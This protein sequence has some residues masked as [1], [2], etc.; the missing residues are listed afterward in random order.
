M[1]GI[2]RSWPHEASLNVG[3]DSSTCTVWRNMASDRFVCLALHCLQ[4]RGTTN[5]ADMCVLL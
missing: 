4:V 3:L 5:V 2:W 1:L